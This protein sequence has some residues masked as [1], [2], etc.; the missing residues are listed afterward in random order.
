M[1]SKTFLHGLIAGTSSY[2]IS[3][4]AMHGTKIASVHS[5]FLCFA[6]IPSGRLWHLIL[7]TKRCAFAPAPSP[8]VS[9][10][11]PGAALSA[12]HDD[13]A[14]ALDLAQQALARVRAMR[15]RP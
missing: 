6:A 10:L 15:E 5:L 4:A 12:P 2:L 13:H 9:D 1:I 14:T 11:I 8:A 7:E 3:N